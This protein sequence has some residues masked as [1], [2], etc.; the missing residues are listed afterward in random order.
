[1]ANVNKVFL[2]GNLTRDPEVRSTPSGASVCTLGLAVNRRY[3][4]SKGED[5]EETCFVDVETWGRQAEN[6]GR[7]LSKG[8]PV[9]VEGRLHQDQWQDKNS[10]ENRS[11]ILIRAENVQ[12]LGGGQTGSSQSASDRD[13]TRQKSNRVGGGQGASDEPVEMPD[14]EPVEDEGTEDNIPF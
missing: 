10:G 6:C 4:T 11:K 9:L 13:E 3:T 2:L 1:M 7:F 8:R 5:R 12:F 14:F